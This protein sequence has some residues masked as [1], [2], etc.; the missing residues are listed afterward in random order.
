MAINKRY[1]WLKLREDFFKMKQYH[2]LKNKK[3][4]NYI[5]YFI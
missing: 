3:M 2:G 4:E 5:V 1:Y